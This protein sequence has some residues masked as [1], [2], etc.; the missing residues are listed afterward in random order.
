MNMEVKD[1]IVI[2]TNPERPKPTCTNTKSNETEMVD[3]EAEKDKVGSQG[4]SQGQGQGQE[5]SAGIIRPS[6]KDL[7]V[8]HEVKSAK[9]TSS[10]STVDENNNDNDNRVQVQD[11]EQE[12]S[13][14][15]PPK[16]IFVGNLSLFS[17]E[18]RLREHF[19][20]FGD[21]DDVRVMYHPD[22]NKSRRFGFITFRRTESVHK[23]LSQDTHFLD[24]KFLQVCITSLSSKSLYQVSEE[25]FFC[26]DLCRIC[27]IL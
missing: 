19:G 1:D 6:A 25:G 18:R 13:A 2:K 8:D 20:A 5:G 22:S 21:V 17:D 27:L 3:E 23:V 14:P 15:G 26:V 12:A 4:Q 24:G 16:D 9:G 10:S 7:P 11:Q